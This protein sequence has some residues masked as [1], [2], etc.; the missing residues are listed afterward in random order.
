MGEQVGT[1]K[2]KSE[3]AS[4]SFF[5]SV[6][7]AIASMS[8]A[9]SLSYFPGP[10]SSSPTRRLHTPALQR[11]HFLITLEFFVAEGRCIG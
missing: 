11:G 3:W 8:S 2:S 5:F 6:L 1:E 10:S 9:P 7:L 4:S